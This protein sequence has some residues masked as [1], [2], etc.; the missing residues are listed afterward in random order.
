MKELEKN[1][2]SALQQLPPY[3]SDKSLQRDYFFMY[4]EDSEKFVS[5]LIKDGGFKNKSYMS[6]SKGHYG[7]G[8]E[9]IHMIIEKSFSG[10]DI[11]MYNEKEQEVLFPRNTSFK[12]INFKEKGNYTVI[13]V[14][15]T[16]N[17]ND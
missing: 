7:Q 16:K 9:Q 6:T 11:S 3:K 8:G 12:V 4:P 5:N 14:G 2:D 13:T 15:E 17:E 1:L 10:R